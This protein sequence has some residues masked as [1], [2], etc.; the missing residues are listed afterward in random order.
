MNKK[1]YL[2]KLCKACKKGED[3]DFR[4]CFCKCVK[5]RNVKRL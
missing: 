5:K 3:I 4:L 1:N 2:K